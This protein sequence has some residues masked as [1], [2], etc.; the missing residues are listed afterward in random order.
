MCL[1]TANSIES[2]ASLLVQWLMQMV[3]K[4]EPEVDVF[5]RSCTSIAKIAPFFGKGAGCCCDGNIY[6]ICILVFDFMDDT[7]CSFDFIYLL[8][9]GINFFRHFFSIKPFGSPE[10]FNPLMEKKM[11]GINDEEVGA[12]KA[13]EERKN[14]LGELIVEY[15]HADSPFEP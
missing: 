3:D 2:M 6:G 4:A 13:K 1:Q 8:W 12:S 14:H 11:T 15:L 5:R 9:K 7:D 10:G